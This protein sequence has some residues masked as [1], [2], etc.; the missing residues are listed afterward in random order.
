MDIVKNVHFSSAVPSLNKKTV[1]K[2][3]Y[4]I[5]QYFYCAQYIINLI[6]HLEL[7]NNYNYC[8]IFYYND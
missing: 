1:Q 5:N 7:A 3:A 8:N 6:M 4:T 2:R